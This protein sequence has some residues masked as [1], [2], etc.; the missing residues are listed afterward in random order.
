MSCFYKRNK[1]ESDVYDYTDVINTPKFYDFG[2]VGLGGVGGGAN[3]KPNVINVALETIGLSLSAPPCGLLPKYDIH[4]MSGPQVIKLGLLEG[5]K[6]GKF[7][8]LYLD[9]EGLPFISE[10]GD[11]ECTIDTVYYS[12]IHGLEKIE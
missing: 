11:V 1:H 5:I 8:E 10:V 4:N 7:Y 12:V 2:Y 9:E 3:P 6:Q